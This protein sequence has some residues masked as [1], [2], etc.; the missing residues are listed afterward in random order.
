[1]DVRA[2]HFTG[3]LPVFQKQKRRCVLIKSE[4]VGC[5][6][7]LMTRRRTIRTRP[8]SGPCGL[9]LRHISD[10]PSWQSNQDW[11]SLRP[12]W[13]WMQP[14]LALTRDS[15][16]ALHWIMSVGEQEDDGGKEALPSQA[17]S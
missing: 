17:H 11:Y 9:W 12:R 13:K 5:S 15:S 2:E 6:K 3:G 14:K 8:V 7:N 4:S 16:H 10:L 1:M